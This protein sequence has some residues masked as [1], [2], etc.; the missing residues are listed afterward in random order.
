MPSGNAAGPRFDAS[1]IRTLEAALRPADA[2][3]WVITDALTGRTKG[4]YASEELAGAAV[5]RLAQPG[6]VLVLTVLH[7]ATCTCPGVDA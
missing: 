3:S 5:A 4:I 6:V 1:E 7:P 2:H